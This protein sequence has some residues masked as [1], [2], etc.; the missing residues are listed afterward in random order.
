MSNPD[1]DVIVVGSGITGGWA[2][3]EFCE[4]GFKTLVLERGPPVEHGQYPTENKAPWNMPFRGL[5]D[6]V[7]WKR[8]YGAAAPYISGL[9]EYSQQ[10]YVRDSEEPYEVAPG[11]EFHW[12][13]GYQLGGK[14]LTWGRHVPRFAPLDFTANRVDGY[15]APWPISYAELAQWY[16]YVEDF[17]GVSGQAEGLQHFPDGKY[18]PPFELTV[19]EQHLK[20]SLESRYPERRLTVGRTA[21]LTR[22]HRGRAPCMSRLHCQRGCS[23]GA[24]F[25][26]LSS[27]LPAARATGNLT[28]RTGH[29]AESF[30][31]DSPGRKVTGLKVFDTQGRSRS[32][33]SARVYFVCGSAFNS[34]H[35]LMNSRSEAHP[36]GLGG[37]SGVLGRYIL[38]HVMGGYAE[39]LTDD[40]PDSYAHGVRPT[41]FVVPR[42]RNIG[43]S[44]SAFKRGYFFWG[45]SQRLGWSRGI[46]SAGVG[47][48]LKDELRRPGPWLVS[49]NSCGEM[50]PRRE[51]YLSLAPRAVDRHGI[52]LLRIT[53]QFSENETAMMRDAQEQAV[54]LLRNAGL[55]IL[56][57]GARLEPGGRLHEMG[58]ARMGAD[59]AQSVLNAYNQCHVAKN[60]FVTD[61]AAMPS[62]SCYNPSLTYM[63]LTA[64]AADY[65]GT[66]LQQRVL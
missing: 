32:K 28:V 9:T 35:L 64:R 16:D 37:D 20:Q 42:F 41:P 26:S 52:P 23:L 17:I 24:Y 8:D 45:Q 36:H 34:V 44:H 7:G 40:F 33:L 5:G 29:I 1:F 10:Y 57:S 62:G 27:T 12:L 21:N 49:V 25:S 43:S 38:D 18:L 61:G 6:P 63:A 22:P 3:K 39:G 53:F 56:G 58:G 48:H 19:V 14:S 59:P 51:N 54:D 50:L 2:A 11:S 31:F 47:A 55:R 66:Q 15:G 60:V 4:R 46:F 65:A 13:R 30:E